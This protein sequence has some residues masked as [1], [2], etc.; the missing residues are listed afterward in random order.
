MAVEEPGVALEN[1]EMN[2]CFGCGRAIREGC[3]YPSAVSAIA[4]RPGFRRT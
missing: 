4:W 2:P 3:A 1:D